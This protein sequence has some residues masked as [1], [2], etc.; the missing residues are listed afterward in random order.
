MKP[1][2]VKPQAQTDWLGFCKG[3]ALLSTKWTFLR[4]VRDRLYES[5]EK[6]C[7]PREKTRQR[8]LQ[9]HQDITV[10][11]KMLCHAGAVSRS[12]TWRK[13]EGLPRTV[14]TRSTP[15]ASKTGMNASPMS[16]NPSVRSRR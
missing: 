9:T 12:Y 7:P 2:E 3:G 4:I 6:R 5:Y 14:N 8:H 13:Y 10:T 11:A 1:Q 16:E 15:S